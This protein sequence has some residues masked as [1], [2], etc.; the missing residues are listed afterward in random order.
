MIV[1]MGE[2]VEI[3]PNVDGSY[4]WVAPDSE[5]IVCQGPKLPNK[6]DVWYV[7]TAGIG[8]QGYFHGVA[9]LY[10]VRQFLEK[11]DAVALHDMI[12]RGDVKW[13]E[14]IEVPIVNGRRGLIHKHKLLTPSNVPSVAD[15][16]RGRNLR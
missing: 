13:Q 6:L 1:D 3:G 14:A 10:P 16:H 7:A 8:S 9:G 12:L 11:A 2:R 5:P 15:L 4:C